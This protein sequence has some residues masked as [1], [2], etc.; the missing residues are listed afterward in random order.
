MTSKV[1]VLFNITTGKLSQR[2]TRKRAPLNLAG[3]A[4]S[5]LYNSKQTQRPITKPLTHTHT[6]AHTLNIHTMYTSHTHEYT[7]RSYP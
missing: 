6:Y 5:Y 7:H 3:V 4:L 2:Q 1:P